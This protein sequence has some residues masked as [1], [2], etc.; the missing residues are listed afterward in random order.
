M[1]ETLLGSVALGDRKVLSYDGEP[2]KEHRKLVLMLKF[3]YSDLSQHEKHVSHNSSFIIAIYM[4]PTC[5]G[6]TESEFF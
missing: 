6:D 1:A 5:I 3:S 4:Q 2:L